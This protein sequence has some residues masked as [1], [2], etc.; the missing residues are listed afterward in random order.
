MSQPDPVP[1]RVPAADAERLLARAATLDVQHRAGT[2]DVAALRHAAVA[3]GIDASAFDAALREGAP[4]PEAAAPTPPW[5][6]RVTLLGVPDR[7]VAWGYYAF[8]TLVLF[9]AVTAAVFVRMLAPHRAAAY[10]P[11]LL[12]LAVWAVFALW[13]TAKSIRWADAHGWDRLP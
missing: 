13:S 3:A 4:V 6:V 12:S 7:R 11:V 10:G 1:Q 8:F 2:V 5:L 9:A